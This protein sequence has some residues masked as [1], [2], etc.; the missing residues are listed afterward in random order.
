MKIVLID[1]ILLILF[2]TFVAVKLIEYTFNALHRTSIQ[3]YTKYT[4]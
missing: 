1:I 3:I 2:Q 4:H